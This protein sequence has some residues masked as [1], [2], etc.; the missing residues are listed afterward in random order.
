MKDR[1]ETEAA[2]TINGIRLSFTQSWTVRVA[3][4]DF[5]MA[6]ADPNAMGDDE[7]GRAMVR[8]YRARAEEVQKL[9]FGNLGSE[10]E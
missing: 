4:A 9:I 3:I 2:I 6:L 1:K 10:P 8:G 7:H 5:L